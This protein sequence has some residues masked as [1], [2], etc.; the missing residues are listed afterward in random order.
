MNIL[1]IGSGGREHAL[2]WAIC[3][4]PLCDKL[5]IAPG[6]PGTAQ[7]GD[8]V[9]LD[10]ADHRAVADFCKLQGV[11][12]VV[13][14]P[15]GPLVD[16]IV[17]DLEA[18]G[19]KTFGPS[20]AAAQLEGSK[21]FTKELCAE[22]GIPT[23]AFARFTDEATA[24]AYVAKTGAPLVIKADGLA[25]GKGVVMAETV[26]QA[27]EALAMMFSG[28]LGAAGAEVVIEEWMIGE[29]ASFFALCDGA[30]ALPLASA[31]DHK[32]AFDGDTG[33]N[34]GGMGAYSPAP[35]MTKAMEAQVMTEIIAP[36]LAGMNQRG[37]PFKGVLF[38]GLMITADGPKLI[39]Y[40]TRFGDPECEVLMPRLKS[41]LVP[42]LLAARDGVL[43]AIDLRWS[44]NVA[45]T[46]V[47]AAKGYPGTPEKGSVIEGIDKAAAEKDVLVFHAGTQAKGNDIV[48]NGG[49][50]LNIVALG[51]SV[52]E[53]Q[54]KA[55]AAVD[56]IDWP[57]GFCRRDIGWQAIKRER[58]G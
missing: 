6:N 13:V 22:F 45:L 39:E 37:T 38:A 20:R 36:T 53:A 43:N 40:N 9:V 11:G 57:G 30:H 55:Y 19:I 49:R 29:E 35:V 26:E 33:P 14:G 54:A 28:G 2:A 5:F 23:A 16:G 15:E 42:A 4:S 47:M 24:K 32:R 3:A 7:C 21:A 31:Q 12:L 50:V 46:V 17:D 27:N 18:A 8:N 58:E 44:D 52:S 56:L 10:I 25:A 34:T 48:A 41:D 51:K 1:L